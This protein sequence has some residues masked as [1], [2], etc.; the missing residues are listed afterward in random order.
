MKNIKGMFQVA[1]LAIIFITFNGCGDGSSEKRSNVITEND[2]F[3]N[4][5]LIATPEHTLV[6]QLEAPDGKGQVNDIGDKGVDEVP[7]YYSEDVTQ[8]F[9][10]EDDTIDAGQR[11]ELIDSSANMVL[12][13]HIDGECSSA[14]VTAGH[15]TMRFTH[16]G[17]SEGTQVVFIRLTEDFS[18]SR[19]SIN[20]A[21]VPQDLNTLITT[22]SCPRCDLSGANLKYAGLSEANLYEANLTGTDLTN[23][24]LVE[25]N[26]SHANL[27]HANLYLAHLN[28]AD[29]SYTIVN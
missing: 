1:L 12:T 3:A 22:N 24:S 16:G 18:S 6:I 10:W 27:S 25:A 28:G 2:L 7:V 15:Y 29:L 23:A 4:P 17:Q 14:T 26:L 13:E 9:C 19:G 11:M 20:T 21:F 5:Q 8:T